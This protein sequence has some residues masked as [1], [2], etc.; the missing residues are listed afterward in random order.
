VSSAA[1]VSVVRGLAMINASYQHIATTA[2]SGISEA[3]LGA[4]EPA[5][6]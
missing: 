1:I 6:P 3:F 4:C 5:L 2:Q